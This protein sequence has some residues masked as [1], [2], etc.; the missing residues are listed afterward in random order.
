[1]AG[2]FGYSPGV[3]G[4]PAPVDEKHRRL[5]YKLEDNILQGYAYEDQQCDG[6]KFYIGIGDIAYCNHMMV[7]MPVG[8]TWWCQWWESPDEEP[9]T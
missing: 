9:L 7:R 2:A 8:A 3:A 6:C 5:V 1:L 4:Y